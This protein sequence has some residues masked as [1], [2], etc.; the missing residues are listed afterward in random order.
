MQLQESTFGLLYCWL[1]HVNSMCLANF[2]FYSQLAC[3][4]LPTSKMAGPSW[5]A[6]WICEKNLHSKL[7]HNKAQRGLQ[8]HRSC[9]LV[10]FCRHGHQLWAIIYYVLLRIFS[11]PRKFLS[12]ILDNQN[13]WRNHSGQIQENKTNICKHIYIYI[14]I[15]I[16]KYPQSTTHFGC[17][18]SLPDAPVAVE[19]R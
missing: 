11:S 1:G 14:R 6:S 15:I 3:E 5:D 19:L 18:E 7:H 17:I 2:W 13:V 8:G 10:L 9:F 4:L 16:Y 12:Q